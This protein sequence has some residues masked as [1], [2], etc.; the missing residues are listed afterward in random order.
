MK[1]Y[2]SI[3]NI[4]FSLSDEWEEILL[5]RC[6]WTHRIGNWV[7]RIAL[8]ECELG[9]FAATNAFDELMLRCKNCSKLFFSSWLIWSH[10]PYNFSC[11]MGDSLPSSDSLAIST[12]AFA[13][14]DLL[15]RLTGCFVSRNIT[16][17]SLSL[18]MM[19][20][21]ILEDRKYWI[22]GKSVVG[23]QAYQ[24]RPTL[25]EVTSNFTVEVKGAVIYI[26][27]YEL[28]I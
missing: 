28:R 17:S 9:A 23:S 7:S 1:I 13:S 2:R 6:C 14:N 11:I 19:E 18:S 26:E 22:Y 24:N 5:D 3:K 20:L 15:S 21:F 10:K 4:P 25:R 12:L 16:S 8:A 27:I